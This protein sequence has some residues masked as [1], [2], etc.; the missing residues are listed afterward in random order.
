MQTTHICSTNQTN[1]HNTTQLVL[2]EPQRCNKERQGKGEREEEKNN[3]REG[4]NRERY[5][6]TLR[7]FVILIP[8]SQNLHTKC[9]GIPFV[10]SSFHIASQAAWYSL[11]S[12][13]N[14]LM[15]LPISPA[16]YIYLDW[17]YIYKQSWQT[18][19]VALSITFLHD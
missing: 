19:V 12:Y 16:I 3:W 18:L 14:T 9:I 8:F 5:I 13:V 2:N 4:G 15:S 10:R 1:A 6:A 17:R 11:T 7:R